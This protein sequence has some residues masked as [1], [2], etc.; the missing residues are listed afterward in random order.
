[1][2]D[3]KKM[4]VS[5]KN[6]IRYGLSMGST[7]TVKCV[8]FHVNCPLLIF[9]KHNRER[10]S[11]QLKQNFRVESLQYVCLRFLAWKWIFKELWKSVIFL[12]SCSKL[13]SSILNSFACQKM[14]IDLTRS[15]SSERNRM[16][17]LHGK[18]RLV[19]KKLI[20]AIIHSI[21]VRE[22]FWILKEL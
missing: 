4:E 8:I 22:N 1:M 6:A 20:Q 15:V 19:F 3:R 7:F 2:A 12:I 14:Q 17:L 16:L 21:H 10:Y 5:P 11:D 18:K 9:W 13:R